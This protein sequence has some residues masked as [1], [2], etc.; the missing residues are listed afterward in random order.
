MELTKKERMQLIFQL[1]IIEKLYPKEESYYSLQRKALEEGYELHY[2]EIFEGLFDGL[3]TDECK[4]VLEILEMYRGIIFSYRSLDD[5]SD[6]KETEV[7]FKGFDGNNETLLMTYT[8]YFIEDLGRYKEI[9]ELSG[10]YYNSHA[11]ML[12]KYRRM[13]QIWDK[14]PQEKRYKMSV[15]ELIELLRS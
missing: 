5:K 10:G 13:L 2:R 9:S 3:T 14:Y 8:N 1:K 7:S 11:R 12:P 6:I 4:E 15:T